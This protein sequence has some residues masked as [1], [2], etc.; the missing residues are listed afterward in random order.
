MY[1]QFKRNKEGWLDAVQ[2]QFR[3]KFIP[4]ESSLMVTMKFFQQKNRM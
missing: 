2:E 1:Q 4:K 3:D